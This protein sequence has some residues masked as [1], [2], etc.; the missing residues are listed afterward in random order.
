[1]DPIE[2]VGLESLSSPDRVGRADNSPAPALADDAVGAFNA[3]RGQALDALV[4]C[5]NWLGGPRQQ[6]RQPNIPDVAPQALSLRRLEVV[7]QYQYDH[8]AT[9]GRSEVNQLL[10]SSAV[11]DGQVGFRQ[12][13]EGAHQVEQ[14]VNLKPYLTEE[15]QKQHANCRL[16][17]VI[18]RAGRTRIR[19]TTLRTCGVWLKRV[20][21]DGRWNG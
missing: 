15:L 17:S 20:V 7:G 8:H 1:L 10:G 11:H 18:V 5:E 21:E 16:F 12:I 9:A 19:V 4:Q 6:S 2:D 14:V 3:L 13:E